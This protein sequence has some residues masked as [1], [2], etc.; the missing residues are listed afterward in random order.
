MINFRNK[1]IGGFINDIFLKK[2]YTSR[3]L[4]DSKISSFLKN[5]FRL[6]LIKYNLTLDDEDDYV[7]QFDILSKKMSLN[8][9]DYYMY[10]YDSWSIRLLRPDKSNL[11]SVTVDYSKVL[12]SSISN[13]NSSESDNLSS[14]YRRINILASSIIRIKDRYRHLLDKKDDDRSMML[15]EMFE[16]LLYNKPRSFDEALQKILFYNGLFWQMGHLH[17]GLGRLDLILFPYYEKD[18]SSGVLTRNQ[19]KFMLTKFCSILNKDYYSKSLGLIGDTGQ[20][21]MIG[22][23]DKNG[24][25]TDNEITSLLLEVFSEQHIPDPKLILRVN[26]NTSDIIWNNS[27]DCISTGIGS[28]LLMNEE[29]I[30]KKMVS[31]GYSSDDVWNVGTS[32]CWEPLIIGKSF[33]QNNSLRNIPIV[34]AL[35]EILRDREPDTFEALINCLSEAIKKLIYK[36][37]SDLNVDSS[38][39]YS[40]FFDN[41]ILRGIDFTKGGAE[42]SFHGIE[43]V[44]FPNLINSLLNIK[45]FVYEQ[46]VISWDECLQFVEN[47]YVG[48]EDKRILLLSNPNKFGLAIPEVVD[49]S[50][51]IMKIV[52]DVVSTI[53]INGKK[54]KVG[55][56]SSEY[57]NASKNFEATLDGRHS[58]EPFAVHISPVSNNIDLG[59]ILEFSSKLDYSGNRIN[60]NVVD[61]IAPNYL[62]KNKAKFISILKSSIANGLFEIQLNVLSA[63]QL[64]DAKIH[65]EKYPDLIVRVWGF[66]AYFND[67]PDVYKDNLIKRAESYE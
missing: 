13:F 47:N 56:S 31:F 43:V 61:F 3:N 38:P 34:A 17:N 66:S 20:Y 10:P 46:K 55:F 7:R 8:A 63:K 2:K 24:N 62:L 50:N 59:E 65:P 30:M 42:Y 29:L 5:Y 54:A 35:N 33:D 11:T 6:K 37:V 4:R 51:S 12:N 25:N 53:T 22:G 1:P 36:Y 58:A 27:I 26:K 14:F 40:L 67:L 32:A 28:P 45:R 60:G 16:Y 19:A 44:S 41:C 64:K 15:F 39:L 21:I 57:I 48:Y 23:V 9:N 18:I 52:S 49:L